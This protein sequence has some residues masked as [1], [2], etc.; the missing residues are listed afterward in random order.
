MTKL[1]K[2]KREDF[3][4]EAYKEIIIIII[5]ISISFSL[6]TSAFAAEMESNTLA[7]TES[8]KVSDE[9]LEVL[10]ISYSD[11]VAGDF[12][13][14]GDVYSCIIWINDIDKEEAVKA[15]IDAAEKTRDAYTTVSNYNYPYT[16]MEVNGKE[17]VEVE[18]DETEDDEYVEAYIE[19]ER[20]VASEMYEI[21]NKRFVTEN[22]I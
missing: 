9:L 19:A 22:L 10:N 3:T 14:N 13:D 16:V 6:M 8:Q 21:Q 7:T 17:V 12:T 18:L 5:G 4:Y 20:A 15:G 1:Q 11:L 2:E